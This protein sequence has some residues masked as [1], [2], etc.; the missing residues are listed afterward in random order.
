M[1]YDRRLRYGLSIAMVVGLAACGTSEPEGGGAD[2]RAAL[3]GRGPITFA[4][5]KDTSGQLPGLVSKWNDAHPDQKVRIVELPESADGARERLIQNAR[6]KSDAFTVLYLDV[7]QTAE[8]A[9]N[10]W[11]AEL[12]REEFGLSGFLSPTVA[13]SEYQGRLYG[14]PWTSGAGLL[15]YREDLLDRAGVDGPPRTWAEMKDACG[16][17]LDLPEAKEM[18]CYAGQFEKYEGLTVNFADA[19]HSAGGH[20]IGPDG[21]PDVDTPEARAGL[22]FLV[23]GFKDGT[24]PKKAVTFTEEE[25]RRAFQAG[26]LVFQRQWSY[27]YALANKKDGSSKVAGRFAV[28]PLPGQEGPGAASLGGSALAISAF[29]KNK[30]TAA[31]FISFVTNEENALDYARA[32]SQDPTRASVY[33]DPELVESRPYYPALREA[34]LQAVPRPQVANY[35]DITQAIQQQVYAAITGKKSSSRALEDLQAK[36]AVLIT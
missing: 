15:Y 9:A 6:T 18:S 12:P 22:D 8:F 25:S 23:E 35:N 21:L 1:R 10:R 33:D 27:Q 7:V 3:E 13:A 36:L 16:K 2:G 4:T 17:V 34:I 30:A 11:V 29:A 32:T 5:A 28:A 20:I 26:E 19:V 31:D 24:I 14:V